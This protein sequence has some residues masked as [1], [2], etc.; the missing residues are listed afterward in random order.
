MSWVLDSSAILA[1]FLKEKG[2]D[3]AHASPGAHYVSAVNFAEV[4]SK[5]KNLGVT[6]EHFEKVR[7]VEPFI[8]VEFDRSQALLSAELRSKTRHLGLPLG[9]RACLALAIQKNTA[10]L[11]QTETG[12]I[13][14]SESKSRSSA[15]ALR[16]HLTVV[17]VDCRPRMKL[18]MSERT[19][20]C[21]DSLFGSF[22]AVASAAM[23]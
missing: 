3:F 7:A 12:T 15:D 23:P 9:D 5:L 4:Y 21:G 18:R 1:E 17:L 13:L 19:I 22:F 2:G 8:V 16:R 6:A 20:S 10:V 14:T 11:T